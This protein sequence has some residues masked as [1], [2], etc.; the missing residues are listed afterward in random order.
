M[1]AIV[2]GSAGP[3]GDAIVAV[4]YD[5]SDPSRLALKWAAEYAVLSHS[6]LRVIHAWIW[7]VFTHNVGP[8]EGVAGSGLRHA[9]EVILEEGTRTVRDLAPGLQ[10]EPRM[11]AG[12][13]A[14]VLRKE[15]VDARVLVVGSRGLGGFLGKLVGSVSVDL[16]GGG[17]CPL[18]VIRA[19]RGEGQPVVACVDGRLR[20]SKVLELSV[21]AA[22]TLR[23]TLSIVHADPGGRV[24]KPHGFASEHARDVLHNAVL[25]A[26]QLAPDLTVTDVL[27]SGQPVVTALVQAGAEAGL[28]VLGAHRRE[29]H[30][31][32]LANVLAHASCNVMIAR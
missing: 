17:P 11:T 4:G 12:L 15:S 8:V 30:P 14:V 18:I 21:Q 31:G 10:V 28:L 16:A 9:A 3:G 29:G 26:Q 32:T 1:M 2:P 24:W 19:A 20:S 7:P 5:G 6:M 22:Q 27:L 25:W 23:T 13:P